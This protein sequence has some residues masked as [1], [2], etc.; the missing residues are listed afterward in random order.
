MTP[1]EEARASVIATAL[2]ELSPSQHARV[3]GRALKLVGYDRNETADVL[4]GA[5]DVRMERCD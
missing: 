4:N 5:I 2:A 1:R 3:I